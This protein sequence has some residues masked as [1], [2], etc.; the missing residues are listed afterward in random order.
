MIELLTKIFGG[1][2]LRVIRLED[3]SI[4][5]A[6][7]QI[8]DSVVMIG[9]ASEQYPPNNLLLHVYVADA[10]KTY[11]LA[12]EQG[13]EGISAP[14]QKPHDTDIRGQFKDFQGNVWAVATQAQ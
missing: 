5:H 7:V 4:M 8:D 13:C 9:E 10:H 3:N 6:E 14:V 2:E 12:L 11:Q 1:K